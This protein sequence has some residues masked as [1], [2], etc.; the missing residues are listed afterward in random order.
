MIDYLTV[1]KF[2]SRRIFFGKFFIAQIRQE[3]LHITTPADIKSQII[4]F[5][6]PV[7]IYSYGRPDK[8][9]STVYIKNN[10]ANS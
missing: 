9:K 5:A 10:N 1:V 8:P 4:E 2:L 7:C 6:R 3:L